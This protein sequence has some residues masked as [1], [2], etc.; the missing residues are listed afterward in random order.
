[1]KFMSRS[2]QALSLKWPATCKVIEEEL[3]LQGLPES[4]PGASDSVQNGF[5]PLLEVIG[6][7]DGFYMKQFQLD[8]F[9]YHLTVIKS[10]ER[11]SEKLA[12]SHSFVKT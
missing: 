2:K 11:L 10:F 9:L 5:A 8:R 12:M 6:G 4:Q 3:G 7:T 1:M